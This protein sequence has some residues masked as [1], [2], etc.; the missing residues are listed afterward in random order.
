[1]GPRHGRYA[2]RTKYSHS[3]EDTAVQDHLAIDRK[4]IRSRKQAGVTGDFLPGGFAPSV[5]SKSQLKE[6][7]RFGRPADLLKPGHGDAPERSA[8]MIG[9]T[10]D[11]MP[12]EIERAM[13]EKWID[14][15][16]C[17]WRSHFPRRQ[18]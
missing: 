2:Q 1:M 15:W 4:I 11:L 18:N 16:L 5:G 17:P 8:V 9:A 13:S 6:V 14:A 3:V 12:I 10:A 7:K